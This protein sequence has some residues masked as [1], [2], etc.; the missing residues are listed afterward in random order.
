VAFYALLRSIGVGPGDEVII[1]GLTCVVVPNAILYLGAR[2]VYVDVRRDTLTVAPDS[3]AQ[4]ISSKTK[5]II[6]QNTFG[7]SADVH[8]IVQM[9][10]A[11]GIAAIED[12]THGFGGTYNDRPNGTLADA[13]FFSTQWNK[14]F[15]TGLGGILLVNRRDWLPAV[16]SINVHLSRPSSWEIFSLQLGMAARRHVLKDANYWRL[17][18]LY[19]HLSKIGLVVGS[20]N[21]TEVESTSIP[22][23]YFQQMSEKQ[24]SWGIRSIA[25]L[26]Q[27]LQQRK[28]A[29]HAYR[30][31]LRRRALWH[32]PAIHDRNN[33]HLKFPI[34]V[35]DRELFFSRAE[36]ASIRLSDWFVSPIH[37]VKTRFRD[38]RL[39]LH[40][41]PV[42]ADIAS[43][44]VTI[45][46]DVSTPYLVCEFL[47]QNSSL[48]IGQN[49]RVADKSMKNLAR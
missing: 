45:N 20:S 49:V 37:P 7:L 16:A 15:S 17:V 29:A 6:I 2:P 25:Q 22:C 8:E 31:V 35:N 4:R 42:A 38:W 13:A 21:A 39:D 34:L 26:P 11:H 43:K 23:G 28:A 12:C 19:R 40:T 5:A 14:P 9:A 3:V 10:H 36:K 27:L 46:T 18:R 44:L 47:E 41:I 32:V 33:S 24:C 48:L 1:P 30:D